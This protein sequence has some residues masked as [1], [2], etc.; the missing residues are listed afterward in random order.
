MTSRTT[1]ALSALL[2]ASLA[3]GATTAAHAQASKPMEKCYGVAKAGKNDCKAGAG[4]TC[5]GTS[6]V[7]YQKDAWKLVPAGTC[8]K[9]KTP[10]GFGSLTPGA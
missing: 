10:K 9:I 6:K 1:T 5:A 7:N 2:L 3:A 8:A 4:T